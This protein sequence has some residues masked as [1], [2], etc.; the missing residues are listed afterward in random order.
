MAQNIYDRPD[1]F[2]G[3]SQLPRQRHGLAG[4]P[5][6]P[7]IRAMLPDIAGRRVLDLGCG[8]GWAARWMRESGA[9]SVLGIDLSE[10][11]I[12]RARPKRAVPRSTI[13]LPISNRWSCPKPRSTS[14]IAR[15]RFT[16]FATSGSWPARSTARSRRAAI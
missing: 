7:A 11:M 3:Y 14:S 2:A 13:G 1:F 4:A 12:D 15:W 5:E 8:F 9:R 10:R 16:M 6:W